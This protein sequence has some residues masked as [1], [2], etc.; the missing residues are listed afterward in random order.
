M[1]SLISYF[2]GLLAF[3][4]SLLLIGCGDN[5]TESQ[6]VETPTSVSTIDTKQ[7]PLNLSVFLDLSDRLERDNVQPSQMFNDTAIV[8]YF[9]DYFIESCKQQK[10][11]YSKNNFQIFFYPA[12]NESDIVNLSKSLSLDMSK[13]KPAEKKVRLKELKSKIDETLSVIYTK[14]LKDRR[15]VG[16][17]IWDF[18]SNK[19]VDKL[20]IRSG[21]RNVLVILTD[22]YLY[23]V[24]HKIKEGNAYSYILPQTLKTNGNLLV[25][26]KDLKDIE[27]IMLEIN[28]YSPSQRDQLVKTLEDWFLNMGLDKDNISINETDNERN[29]EI[30]IDNFMNRLQ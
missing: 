27:I 22:G 11:I 21:Y 28:P 20:C 4:M 16:C 10:I 26:R 8:N 3:P 1:K 17:D 19:Q 24:N 7:G 15:W 12:P 30:I 13:L 29:T 9:I 2:F 14:T 5:K 23:H 25:R 18:F 6:T